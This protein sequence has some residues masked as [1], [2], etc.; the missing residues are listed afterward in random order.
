VTDPFGNAGD[1]L[2]AP[3][4]LAFAIAPTDGSNLAL[5][6]KALYVGN[7]GD[8]VLRAVGSDSDVVLRNVISGSVIAIRVAAIRQTGTTASNIVGLA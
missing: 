7:G 2:I 5:G 4:R 6:T 8:I 1:S 3:A